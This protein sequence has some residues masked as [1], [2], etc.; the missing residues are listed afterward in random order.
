M[1]TD[2]WKTWELCALTLRVQGMRGGTRGGGAAGE[3]EQ[4][5]IVDVTSPPLMSALQLQPEGHRWV[6][7]W[8]EGS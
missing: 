7:R 2:H 6:E 3:T 5:V 8:R 4:P 1:F